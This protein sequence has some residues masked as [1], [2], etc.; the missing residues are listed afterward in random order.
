MSQAQS[1]NGRTISEELDL[2]RKFMNTIDVEDDK[3]SL[4]S[5]S[6]LQAWL[7]EHRLLNHPGGADTVTDRDLQRAR[8]L[9][10]A[11]RGLARA[12]HDRIADPAA[13][14]ELNQLA[15]ELPLAVRFGGVDDARLVPLG[16]GSDAALAR[17]VA[18]VFEA[19][20]ERTWER[21]KICREDTC[22]WA[23]Y[24]NSR[25]RSGA[26]CSMAVCGNRNKVRRYQQRRKSGEAKE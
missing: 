3:D 12:N 19:M 5:P 11:L 18:A 2:V 10:H 23:F 20:Q 13:L 16:T 21:V 7:A 4:L 25:N 14:A 15:A 1:P 8:A 17:L 9:R 6:D 26:W 24:D 22:Q